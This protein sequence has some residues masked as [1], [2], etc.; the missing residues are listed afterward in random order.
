VSAIL[1]SDVFPPERQFAD[2]LFA[3][4]DIVDHEPSTGNVWK[5]LFGST[6]PWFDGANKKKCQTTNANTNTNPSG[7]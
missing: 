7:R 2:A 6:D 5:M 1:F 4:R 3:N